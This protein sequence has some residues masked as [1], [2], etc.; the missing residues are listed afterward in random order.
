MSDVTAQDSQALP[1]NKG[2]ADLNSVLA[3]MCQDYLDR[4]ENIYTDF[5]KEILR[6]QEDYEKR[7]SSDTI[8]TEQDV[9]SSIN[10][11]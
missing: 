4:I 11:E 10:K 7:E 6:I 9:T 8:S 1:G 5:S 2:D 3:D